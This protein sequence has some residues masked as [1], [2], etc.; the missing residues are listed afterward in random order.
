MYEITT[1]KILINVDLVL[2]YYKS[3]QPLTLD[4]SRLKIQFRLKFVSSLSL[5]SSSNL[6]TMLKNTAYDEM[7]YRCGSN[8]LK[9]ILITEFLQV[10]E[11]NDKILSFESDFLEYKN[12]FCCYYYIDECR[13]NE[14]IEIATAI[15][16]EK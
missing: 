5:Q 14:L 7:K 9:F 6:Y 11:K 16:P 15:V 10:L 13:N 12:E 2:S 3:K 8:S 4:E 1:S